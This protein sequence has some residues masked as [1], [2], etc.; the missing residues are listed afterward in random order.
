MAG[1]KS[2]GK[3]VAKIVKD[4]YG[5]DYYKRIGSTGGKKSGTGGFWYK[6][7]IELD[8]DFIKEQGKKGGRIS[9]PNKKNR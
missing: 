9:R 1:T 8:D 6:K 4:K 7:H 3:K 2:G 5:K